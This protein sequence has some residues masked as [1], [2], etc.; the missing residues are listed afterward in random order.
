MYDKDQS[1]CY[2]NIIFA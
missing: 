2:L 1:D